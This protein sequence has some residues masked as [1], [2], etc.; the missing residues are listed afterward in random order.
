M[1]KKYYVKLLARIAAV[2]GLIFLVN[3]GL[4]P[5]G[6]RAVF[7]VAPPPA[8]QP[9]DG[10]TTD[11]IT[12]KTNS[13]GDDGIGTLH[14][15]TLNV[16]VE[17][18]TNYGN[19]LLEDGGLL[20]ADQIGAGT[21]GTE[22]YQGTIKV[23]GDLILRD[24]GEVALNQ[25]TL[26]VLGWS[27]DRGGSV[28]LFENS[29]LDAVDSELNID[30]R[31][32][33]LY[34]ASSLSISGGSTINTNEFGL[35]G[36]NE[37]TV[38]DSTIN[39]SG[40]FGVGLGTGDSSS[41]TISG[42]SLE[43]LFARIGASSTTTVTDSDLSFRDSLDLTDATMSQTRGTL[44]FGD[45]MG[46]TGP[47]GHYTMNSGTLQHNDLGDTDNRG[48]LWVSEN[49]RLDLDAATVD[50][51][52]GGGTEQRFGV[53]S[54]GQAAAVDSSVTA[55]VVVAE[56]P[57]SLYQQTRGSLDTGLLISEDSGEISLSDTSVTADTVTANAGFT[58]SGSSINVAGDFSGRDSTT[59][60]T[61]SSLTTGGHT[62]FYDNSLAELE[63]TT[64]ATNNLN[65]HDTSSLSISG[66][67]TINT[68]EF[69]LAGTNELTVSGSIL[70]IGNRFGVGL[71]TGD[72]SLV[73]I[74]NSNVNAYQASI[75]DKAS[76]T[77]IDS[78][79]TLQEGSAIENASMSQTRG[80]LALGDELFINQ[81]GT[82]TL[83][84][85]DIS[86]QNLG[87]TNNRGTVWTRD[88]GLFEMTAST[89]D[90]AS[91]G[92]TGQ[93]LGVNT[94][95]EV[96]ADHSTMK[97]KEVRILNSGSRLEL[98][99]STLTTETLTAENGGVFEQTNS[100]VNV[101][102][103]TSE[104]TNSSLILNGGHYNE[105]GDLLLNDSALIG[106]DPILDIGG[107]FELRGGTVNISGAAQFL[108]G[109]D[110]V[111]NPDYYLDDL[112]SV[113]ISMLG[114]S[115]DEGDGGASFEFYGG[116]EL[117]GLFVEDSLDLILYDDLL[118]NNLSF[119][120]GG[121]SLDLNGFNLT[122]ASSFTGSEGQIIVNGGSFTINSEP[123]PEPATMVLF[124]TGLAGLAGSRFRR[125]K[126]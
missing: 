103:N 112:G 13:N 19:L 91:A 83:S 123:I 54:G 71:G 63:A 86:H 60:L 111:F 121:S 16:G 33:N 36:T 53:R 119:A 79:F 1:R 124:G 45:G 92:G 125:R 70:N 98:T 116:M 14:G 64:L 109:D 6:A 23:G 56:N 37:L 27:D 18:L 93:L 26:N 30:G 24:L 49:G 77:A 39:T 113:Q 62:T 48:N 126:K 100:V 11:W 69:G 10:Q 47:D 72:S 5:A 55:G 51:T 110:F 3:D 78:D 76:L 21:L 115:D 15:G 28:T 25:D 75:I 104:Y 118:V 38:A 4:S 117:G 8:E 101:T 95:G 59:S 43:A 40:R 81:G 94:G 20:D 29:H 96:T 32:L 89:L 66:G 22:Q 52:A 50:L 80:S 46:I 73:N 57:G 120:G 58:A 87:D 7:I 34:H 42:S 31:L 99:G 108:I 105:A 88:G 35:A 90:L 97:I 107:D 9:L 17:G 44:T 2:A 84:E 41:I 102:G 106:T 82:L 85:A 61:S 67:S 65:L 74:S 68:N 114:T 122:V 12:I